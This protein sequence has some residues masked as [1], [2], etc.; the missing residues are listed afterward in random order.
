MVTTTTRMLEEIHRP[1]LFGA[2]LEEVQH[3]RADMGYP[4]LVTPVS[5]F[6]ITQAFRNVVDGERWKSV[7]DET[8]RYFL[9]HYGETPAPVNQD[10]ADKVLSLPQAEELRRAEPVGV[11]RSRFRPGISDEELLLRLT[12]PE[13]QVDAI[14]PIGA[15]RHVARPPIVQLLRELERRQGIAYVRV[16]KDDDL[17]EWRRAS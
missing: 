6:M 8:V 10:V 5:Q 15:T 12:M 14:Q 3:V 4:I 7:S 13:E 16:E 1:E 11:D 2:V 9:G 17:L